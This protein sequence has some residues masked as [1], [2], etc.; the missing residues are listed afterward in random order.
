V[1]TIIDTNIAIYLRDAHIEISEAIRVLPRA[2]MMSVVTRVELEGGIHR[3]P[4]DAPALRSRV[5]ALLEIMEELPFT[6][7]EA[8]VYGRIVARCGFSRA[9]IIDRMIAATAIVA[10]ATLITINGD[11]FRDIQGLKLDVWPSPTI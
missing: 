11:D 10:D 3:N 2:P 5:D 9:R 4:A 8:E 7:A 1:R 6:S